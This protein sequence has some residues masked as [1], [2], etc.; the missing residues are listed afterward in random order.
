MSNNV[1]ASTLNAF[2]FEVTIEGKEIYLTV[3]P[4]NI[5][6]NLSLVRR[7]LDADA[8]RSIGSALI[9]AANAID[10][11][12]TKKKRSKKKGESIETT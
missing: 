3:D 2:P 11:P 12:K 9:K 5:Q 1:V 7:D 10:K 8:A 6:Q 4:E